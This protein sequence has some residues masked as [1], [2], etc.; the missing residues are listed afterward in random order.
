MVKFNEKDDSPDDVENETQE[1]ELEEVLTQVTDEINY[2]K[3]AIQQKRDLFRERFDDYI[4]PDK[5]DDKV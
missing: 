2:S 4:N 1:M 3:N 5:A